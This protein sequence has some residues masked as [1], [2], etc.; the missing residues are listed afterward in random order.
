ME[1]WYVIMLWRTVWGTSMAASEACE[2][3]VCTRKIKEISLYLL[4]LIRLWKLMRDCPQKQ[5]PDVFYKKGVFLEI[6]QTSQEN[7]CAKVS[8]LITLQAWGLQLY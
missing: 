5:P 2:L 6:S 4:I 8:F 3:N 1:T 7:T